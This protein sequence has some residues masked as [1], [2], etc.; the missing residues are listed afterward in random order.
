MLPKVI[1]RARIWVYNYNS[2]CYSDNAQNVDILGLGESFLEILW[3]AR[4]KDIGRRPLVFI[5]SCFGGIVV[6]QVG[7]PRIL[8]CLSLLTI[9][10]LAGTRETLSRSNQVRG[11]PKVN[12]RRCLFRHSIARNGNSEHSA[13]D[14]LATRIYGQRDVFDS[15]GG[16]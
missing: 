14:R 16:T 13:M 1:P 3:I 5:G 12:R 15:S 4:D 11:P 2:N 6:A 7:L 8:T 10:S 9:T